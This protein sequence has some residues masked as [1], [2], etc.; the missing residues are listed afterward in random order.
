MNGYRLYIQGIVQGVGFR[1]FIKSLA[2]KY[3]L[4]G[5][6]LN[7]NNGVEVDL[8]CDE[9][10][11]DKFIE[12]I[13]IYAPAV[14]HIISIEKTPINI[15]NLSDFTIKK[16]SAKS[17][18][19]MVSPD[20]AICNKCKDE[21]DSIN[22]NRYKYPFTNC[23]NCGPRY[24]ITKELPY[25]RINTVM[26]T[27]NMCDKCKFEYENTDDRRFHA[28]PIACSKCGPNVYLT[29]LGK[30]VAE[31]VDAIK[32][33]AEIINDGNIIALKG[34]GGY[35]LI[36]DAYNTKIIEKLRY[37]KNRQEKPFALMVKNIETL[38]KYI[39]LNKRHKDLLTSS[40]SPIVICDFEEIPFSPLINPLS[41][42]IGVMVAYT[43]LHYILFDYLKS[44]FIIA[45]SGNLRDEPICISEDTAERSLSIFT[46]YFLHHNREIYNRV[47]DSVVA[48][49]K[50][51][52]T[53]FRR[54]RGFAPYPV[55]IK[56]GKDRE[57][58]E[59]FAAGANLKS[60]IAFF[61]NN[62][63]FLSQYIGD[64]DNV[65][66]MDLYEETFDRMKKLFN[67]NVK[68]ALRDYHKSYRSSNFA[69]S[70]GVKTID[71]QHHVAHFS[72]C[73][74]ENSYYGD[75][76][77]IIMDGFGLGIDNE[78]WGG[79]FFIKKGDT[80]TRHCHLKKYLQVG[81]DS[82]SKN[83]IRMIIS[84]LTE[85]NILDKYKD[86]IKSQVNID[87]KEISLIENICR[88]KINSIYTSSAG[89]LF[90]S[91]GSL[92]L[93]K[94]SN[95]YEG[96]L[97]IGLENICNKNEK[98]FYQF[99]FS[100]EEI[101]FINVIENIFSD[102]KNNIDKSIIS[103]KFHNG[104]AIII[105]KVAKQLAKENDINVVALSG[106]VFQNVTLLNKVID[107]LKKD[108]IDILIH[109]KVPSN[110]GGI[111]LGQLYYYT[112]NLKFM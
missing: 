11:A 100:N 56:S 45:T 32:K 99:D 1:P 112:Q 50:K 94:K 26:A 96:A 102:I 87:D 13:K 46:N 82:A 39:K 75:A 9:I 67:I 33:T 18:V 106:G 16:S 28:Q 86:I 17:G 51:D 22:E 6:V 62:F 71:I 97:A 27:F 44:D 57:N 47:D 34:L 10:V 61:K 105:S 38:E 69:D 19:T 14:S 65:E 8:L 55:V 84:Y 78:S 60:S 63:C 48:I 12:D 110:D 104:F 35:H 53:I 5:S 91:V 24:S 79:E 98:S 42:K 2:T 85:N 21:I 59:I 29:H 74:C 68:V 23:T 36:C 109:K 101:D 93:G 58:E 41:N 81:L 73:L 4:K 108:N 64:L 37:L 107:I 111:S 20:I 30:I 54:A 77:G 7:S 25:D 40:E 66:T 76:V 83:P 88:K 95:E 15:E 90:E 31:K 80:I 49:T 72:S 103:A 52:Y 43:P 70:L 92:V 3:N 89:R